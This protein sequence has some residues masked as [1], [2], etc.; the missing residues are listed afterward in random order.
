MHR[1]ISEDCLFTFNINKLLKGIRLIKLRYYIYSVSTYNNWR[2]RNN[3][4]VL[5]ND[6]LNIGLFIDNLKVKISQLRN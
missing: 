5:S 3:T 4:V 6:P 2:E 1:F